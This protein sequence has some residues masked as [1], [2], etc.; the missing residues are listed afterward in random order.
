MK[1]ILIVLIAAILVITCGTTGLASTYTLPEKIHNQLAIGSGLK[2]TFSISS[3]GDGFRTPFVQAVSDAEFSIRGIS[4]G[5]DFHYFVFQTNAEDQQTALSELYRRDGICYFRSDMVQSKILSLPTAEQLID[6]LYPVKG[7]NVSP[8]SF[9]LKILLLPENDFKGK[10]EPVLARYQN[11]L[12]LWLA[13]YT[14]KAETVKLETGASALDFTYEI[15]MDDVIREFLALVGEFTRDSEASALLDSVMTPEQKQIYANPE[16]ISYYQEAMDS[17][18]IQETVCLSKRVTAKGE[19]L[20]SRVEL[21]MDET[22]TGYQMMSIEKTGSLTA[23]RMTGSGHYFA[24]AV[25][26]AENTDPGTEQRSV[27]FTRVSDGQKEEKGEQDISVRIDILRTTETYE[28][29]EDQNHQKDH[30]S[31]SVQQDETYLPAAY[32][33]TVLQPFDTLTLELELHYY[34]KYAQN[35]KTD[36]DIQGKLTRGDSSLSLR[37]SLKTAKP[38]VFMPFEVIDPIEIGTDPAAVLDPYLTDWVS[39]ASSMIHYSVPASEENNAAADSE[40]SD[41]TGGTP[42]DEQAPNE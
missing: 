31:V 38:W 25:N 6:S 41:E 22:T 17:L 30:Y 24:V 16:L 11:E 19:V 9:L 10:W 13:G 12:E 36:L 34:S 32:D 7:E 33:H 29:N 26:H 18:H 42:Q 8:S 3:E 1:K 37:A 27:W 14:V 23:Y 20:S 39:N 15:P 21:P 4:S 5:S 40:P 28:D 35:S 2:G